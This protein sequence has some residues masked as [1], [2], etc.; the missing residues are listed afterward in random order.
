MKKTVLSPRITEQA[1]HTISKFDSKPN[2]AAGVVLE[3]FHYLYY[4]TLREL[5]GFF[6]REEL[7]FIILSY[8]GV[9]I[10]PQ[11]LPNKE[12]FQMH[13]SDY[14]EFNQVSTRFD[15][16]VFLKKCNGLTSGQVYILLLEIL[17]HLKNETNEDFYKK[18]V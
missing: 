14:K 1:K 18:L 7:D 5:K 17:R 2:T 13:L 10:T 6:N 4:Q 8:Y 16:S 11:F 15:F 9:V 3:S 12:S